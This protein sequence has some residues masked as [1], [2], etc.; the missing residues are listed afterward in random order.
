[1]SHQF[2]DYDPPK[3]EPHDYDRQFDFTEHEDQ[4]P[5]TPPPGTELDAEFDHIERALDETQSRLRMVQR[6][7]GRLRNKVVT[8]ESLSP[9]VALGFS[10]PS[11]WEPLT[12]YTA[13]DSV[14]F[15]GA[16]YLSTRQHVS[17]ESFDSDL[18]DGFW[19]MALNFTHHTDD[20]EAARDAAEAARDEAEEWAAAAAQSAE[21][22]DIDAHI[23]AHATETGGVHGIPEGERALH[24]ADRVTQSVDSVAD[25]RA[26]SF[27][28]SLER[29]R[30]SGYYGQGTPG[31]GPLYIDRDDT[32]S[33]DNG[34]TVFVTEDGLRVKRPDLGYVDAHWFG[35]LHDGTGDQRERFNAFLEAGAGSV[36]VF[37]PGTVRVDGSTSQRLEMSG[38]AF[39][40]TILKGRGGRWSS[41]IR[42]VWNGD[43]QFPD[44]LRVQ[45]CSRV[46]LENF[47]VD[48]IEWYEWEIDPDDRTANQWAR[49]NPRNVD[50]LT[51]RSL[52]A[53]HVGNMLQLNG[54]TNY[55][56]DDIYGD[57]AFLLVHLLPGTHTGTISNLIGTRITGSTIDWGGGGG[58]NTTV[59][60][61]YGSSVGAF[62]RTD[63][64]FDIGGARDVSISNSIGIG[65]QSGVNLKGESGEVFG[66]IRITNCHFLDCLRRGA[67]ITSGSESDTDDFGDVVFNNC[68]LTQTDGA[69][70]G[71]A[72]PEDSSA[73]FIRI[74]SLYTSL[75]KFLNCTIHNDEEKHDAIR[76]IMGL[77]ITVEQCNITSKGGG[78]QAHVTTARQ[79]LGAVT[80]ADND[81]N[82]ENLEN[83]RN[84]IR[85]SGTNIPP[86]V[87]QNRVSGNAFQGIVCEVVPW[88][89][90]DGNE[91][92]GARGR[93]VISQIRDDVS[94]FEGDITSLLPPG[95]RVSLSVSDNKIRNWGVDSS[96]R[97]AIR[98]EVS[99][100]GSDVITGGTISRNKMFVDDGKESS[101][102]ALQ[103]SANEDQL[104]Y[105]W[106]SGNISNFDISGGAN[107]GPNRELNNLL[108]SA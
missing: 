92:E 81:I 100:A 21:D 37:G 64:M 23:D 32:T 12:E 106:V 62:R 96:S 27:P 26:A 24:T 74:G 87:M 57:D 70:K 55:T 4:H 65:F 51:V 7:D 93:A 63:E 45:D 2:D 53:Q 47:W 98:V 11:D 78:V 17:S 95:R 101:Q 107:L 80:I 85:A 41:A 49:I 38:A 89:L 14:Y 69:D 44:V 1:M 94:D 16:L 56:I 46:T 90:I 58:N 31:G 79:P 6:D 73:G 8:R 72:S 88:S 82:C 108:D 35:V 84:G 86:R 20:S 104:D 19:E 18:G 60:N 97:A 39:D 50:Q 52:G 9:E 22:A 29:I 28:D 30:L 103:F 76:Y 33:E 75:I 83:D 5:G 43:D 48:G 3:P 68:T 25:L 67:S 77:S 59:T 91:V 66:N 71:A 13:T 102:F 105:C 61:V 36:C 42:P 15:S 99:N 10:P 34:G 40:G 54:T